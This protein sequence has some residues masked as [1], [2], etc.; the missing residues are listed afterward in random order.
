MTAPA[1]V[2]G[3]QVC[4]KCGEE[5]PDRFRLCGLCGTK[6]GPERP[7]QDVRKTV[8]IL[9]SD[10]KGSTSLGEKLDTESLRE[11]LNVY[12][13]EMKRVLES[14]GGTVEKYIGDAIMAVFGLP[15]LHEDDALR[16]VRA[17]AEMQLALAD[18]NERLE[19]GWGVRLENRTGVN[20]GEVVAGD[21]A[22]GQRLV[23]GDAVNTAARLEQAAPALGVLIS[24]STYRL[25]KDAVEVKPVEPLELKGK[26][27]RVP[28]YALVAVNGSEGVARRLDAPM[29][30]RTEE[31][32]ILRSSLNRS[33]LRRG[34]ELITVFGPA[35]VG[36]SRLLQEFIQ[37]ERDQVIAL[38]GRCLS[39][40]EGVTFWPLAE[41]VRGA[42]G[43]REGD[44]LERALTKLAKLIGQKDEHIIER[45]AAAIG[46]S[47]EQFPVEETFWAT[48]QFFERLALRKPV[49]V[50]IED[51]HWAEKT[52]LEL[53]RHVVDSSQAAVIIVCTARPDLLEDHPEWTEE[54]ENR[55]S[56]TLE[57][58]SEEECVLIVE[59]LLGTSGFPAAVRIRIMES[60]EGNPLFVE[61]ML[62]M[63]VDDGILRRNE[64]GQWIL[65]SDLSSFSIPPSISALL[66]ARLDRLGD[67]ERAVIE[68]GSV[69]G[70]VFWRGAVEELA[71]EEI[72]DAVETSLAILERKELI[73]PQESTLSGQETYRFGHQLIRDA[74]Y[75]GLLKRTRAELH[76][77]LVDWLEQVAPDRMMEYDEIRGYHLEQSYMIL[78]QLG[79]LDDHGQQLG[80][81]GARYLSSAGNRALV[82][83]DLPAAANLLRRAAGLLPIADPTRQRLLLDAGEALIEQGEFMMADA[84]LVEA[85]Q[86]A[87]AQ[88]DRWLEL[89]IQVALL[90]LRY[91]TESG[92]TRDDVVQEVQGM[93]PILEDAG[94]YEGLS[95]AWKFLTHVHWTASRY[96]AAKE[97]AERVVYHAQKAGNS[98]METRF[99][100][101]FAM[102]AL[103]G[104]TPVTEALVL[105]QQLQEKAEGDRRTEGLVLYARS[106]LEA[107]QGEFDRARD[108]YRKS[109][110][111][112]EEYGWNFHAALTSI[113]SGQ[114]EML[115]GDP[116]AA[117]AELRRDFEKLEQMGE[118]DYLPTIAAY[119]SESLYQQGRFDDALEFTRICEEH[120]AADDVSS[121]FLWPCV[122]GKILARHGLAPEGEA[123][124][125]QGLSVIR[126]ADEPDSQAGAL[127][128]LAEVL[129]LAGRADEALLALKEAAE[130][131]DR[132]GNVVSSLRAVALQ[133]QIYA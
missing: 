1:R 97:A 125:R 114:V 40:G 30:G 36:K 129:H 59:N 133:N 34:P 27:E 77:R 107:M 130:L 25:V 9:F 88:P 66:T 35:G 60:S 41:V 48:A 94:E 3:V 44:S 6:L 81:R 5:N 42:A 17:A 37:G 63:L 7:P 46:L 117:E 106:H 15:R 73:R 87:A 110:A 29:V 45:V 19:A 10:L 49:I 20:T 50:V 28:A 112:L 86:E 90:R 124:V 18:V 93:I 128:D 85:G 83:G 92:E 101:A 39:Y 68:R 116:V 21:V 11:V 69:I 80:R 64:D 89:T 102:C 115:A 70:Q 132:K 82:R 24:R 74:A 23:T 78:L 53:I 103:Y 52:F 121:Q 61:Q 75:H 127:M 119:L 71:P 31:L 84:V 76:E 13:A 38:R 51:I 72:C 105:C 95:R 111:I 57:L 58:L 120:A 131:F 122:R 55:R 47:A 43:I 56:M 16:A 62:S 100:P 4:P 91:T 22:S 109:R 26:A 96:G 12:F 8:T 65:T 108:L 14:H 123:L 99:L 79:P 54:A 118:R 104:P 98:L 126:G 113:T 2:S 33:I 67:I 32:E